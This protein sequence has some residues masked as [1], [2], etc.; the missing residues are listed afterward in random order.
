MAKKQVALVVSGGS[1]LGAYMAGALDELLSAFNSAAGEYEVDILT[2]S[3]AGATTVSVLAHQLLYRGGAAAPGAAA[4]NELHEVWVEQADITGLLQPDPPAP[5]GAA[6]GP[7]PALMNGAYLHDLATAILSRPIAAPQPAPCCAKQLTLAVTISNSTPLP[8]P[9]VLPQPA[10]GR[11]EPFVQ[12]RHTEQ[13][14]FRLQ[15]AL[16]P[17][18]PV[19]A[20]VGEVAR[21]SA[22]IPFVFPQV[23]L[24][25]TAADPLQYIQTPLFTGEGQFLYYDGGIFNGLPVDLAW[26]YIQAQAGTLADPREALQNRILVVVNPWRT[27]V[28]G[29]PL[30]PAYPGL[31]SNALGLL[32]AM[33]TESAALQF[34]HEVR[35]LAP[36]ANQPPPDPAGARAIA[37][38]D[39]AP[40]ELLADFALVLPRPEDAAR[41]LR[42]SYLHALAGFFD[43]R[44]REYDYR[45]G[46]ADARALA[47][48]RLQIAYPAPH[49]DAFYAPDAAPDLAL[50]GLAGPLTYE[51]L[52]Q[53]P[54]S[55]EPHRMIKQ[56]F[57]D[58]LDDRIRFLLADFI[59]RNHPPGP[60]VFYEAVLD[61]LFDLV[62]PAVHR[63][64]GAAWGVTGP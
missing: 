5:A 13:E 16:S 34:D 45:R 27:E 53:L 20:R 37:G 12:L 15:P 57:E 11:D 54:S 24:T 63:E 64:V 41:P 18:D 6:P 17:A 61:R 7:P 42:G 33:R 59:H 51:A 48:T 14:T 52:G 40:V 56:V 9:S 2:G 10:A 62:R 28:A 3:S 44:F 22:A 23:R 58:A 36:V 26:H 4:V 43:R 30:L 38:V 25:R 19:W 8:Y 60:D 1:S 46:A 50:G 39:R 21:A 31:V 47:R 32:G 29:P 49:A 35:G 55:H